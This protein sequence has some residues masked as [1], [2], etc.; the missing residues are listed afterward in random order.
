VRSSLKTFRATFGQVSIDR[1][2]SIEKVS[3]ATRH[4]M[5][6]TTEAYYTRVRSEMVFVDLERAFERPTSAQ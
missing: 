6:E 1:G 4:K 2:A 5:T 3:G